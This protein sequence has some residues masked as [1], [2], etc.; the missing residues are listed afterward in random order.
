MGKSDS[1]YIIINAYS[2]I[3]PQTFGVIPAYH[4]VAFAHRLHEPSIHL[5]HLPMFQYFLVLQAARVNI[6]A[7]TK[8]IAKTKT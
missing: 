4:L 3:N 6:Y 8:K 5:L 1:F 2:H 7:Q